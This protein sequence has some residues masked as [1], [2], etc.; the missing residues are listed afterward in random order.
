MPQSE[1][2]FTTPLE[3]LDYVLSGGTIETSHIGKIAEFEEGQYLEFKSGQL[4]TEQS[5]KKNSEV[6]RRYISGFA[7]AE[8]G[9][10]VLGLEDKVPENERPRPRKVEPATQFGDQPL[11]HWASDCLGSVMPPLSPP[12]RTY[13]AEVEGGHV[14]VIGIPRLDRMS[15]VNEAGRPVHYLRLGHSTIAAPDYLVSDLVLGRRQRPALAMD[16]VGIQWSEAN[17]FYSLIELHF[18]IVNNGL[19]DAANVRCGLVTFA[20]PSPSPLP[21]TPYLRSLVD[22]GDGDVEGVQLQ[23]AGITD[24]GGLVAMDCRKANLSVN[25][26]TPV[27]NRASFSRA[28]VYLIPNSGSPEWFELDVYIPFELPDGLEPDWTMETAHL[29]QRGWL[30]LRRAHQ[31]PRVQWQY[32]HQGAPP[33]P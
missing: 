11:E 1:A 19:S 20:Q 3:L 21:M 29:K 33:P 31:A 25:W 16:V 5:K 23:H 30:A 22:V 13:A 7:N 28:A 2:E 4:T 10:F 17:D 14:L 15:M 18:E 8:G 6:L 27:R 26:R 12:P 32:I 24:G 9:V